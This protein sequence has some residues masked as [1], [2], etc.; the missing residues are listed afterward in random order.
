MPDFQKSHNAFI[1]HNST[2]SEKKC[3]IHVNRVN[4]K[5]EAF[6]FCIKDTETVSSVYLKW[7][8]TSFFEVLSSLL[9]LISSHKHILTHTNMMHFKQTT[10]E[11]I[12]ST[13]C[14]YIEEAKWCLSNEKNA[15]KIN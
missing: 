12:C 5:N 8:V 11:M 9:Q 10:D 13:K 4:K 1:E 2:L 6:S 14:L 3:S 7:P 15:I